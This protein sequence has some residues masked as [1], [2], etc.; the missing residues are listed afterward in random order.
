MF[1]GD[2]GISP[3][4]YSPDRTNFGPRFG[5]AWDPT[6]K[7]K[8][9]VRS[10]FGI[11]YNEPESELTLQFL[12]A[13]PYGAQV[14][15]VGSTDMTHPYQ[16]SS[17]PLAQ[18]P[19]PFA[20]AKPGSNFDF[21]TVAPVSLTRMDPNFQTPSAM[22]YSLESSMRSPRLDRIRGL[23]GQPGAPSGGSPGYRSGPVNPDRN[24]QNEP[25]RNIYNL[26]NP[27]DAAYGGAV[28]GNI[29]DQLSDANSSY[30]SLQLSLQKRTSTASR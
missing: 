1:P 22:Q 18:N 26:G 24:T 23:R 8:L 15:A 11:F 21:T 19:F 16:T 17:T 20:P 2:P 4:T 9:V 29:T 7:G 30:S 3:S 6:G 27:Q 14:V 28:F 25:F 13:A 5:L 12:G 10:G